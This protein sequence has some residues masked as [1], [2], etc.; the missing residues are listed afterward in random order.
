MYISC[1]SQRNHRRRA[2]K[3]GEQ[4]ISVLMGNPHVTAEE[5]GKA[6]VQLFVILFGGKQT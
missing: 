1:L 4:Q 5:I 3:C 2:Y 6:G